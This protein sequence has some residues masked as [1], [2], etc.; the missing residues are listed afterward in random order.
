MAPAKNSEKGKKNGG[1]STEESASKA[2]G[3]VHSGSFP[4]VGIGASAGGLE[5]LSTLLKAL[6]PDLG[7]A[8]I[9]VPH[10]DPSR[11]SAFAQILARVTTMEVLTIK[12]GLR[13]E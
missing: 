11:E 12:K 6:P 5:A 4:V 10:L 7:M 2:Q 1:T 9:I 3:G 13:V 8:F